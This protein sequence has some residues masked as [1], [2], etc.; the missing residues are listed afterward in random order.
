[1]HFLYKSE[2]SKITR[3]STEW[4]VFVTGTR[5]ETS[6]FRSDVLLEYYAAYGGNSLPTFESTCRADLQDQEIQ[7]HTLTREDG[8]DGT[9][10]LPR[11]VCKEF[12]LYT[13]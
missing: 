10:E 13:A 4:S 11:R 5:W 6:D 8:T 3:N 9:D 7:E 2:Q 12:P 1:M